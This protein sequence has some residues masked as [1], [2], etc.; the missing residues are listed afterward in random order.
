MTSD[1][2]PMVADLRERSL[3]TPPAGHNVIRLLPPLNATAE[4]LARSVEIFRA[5]LAAR[6]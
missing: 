4:E 5:A 2:G 1:P 6:A 3:L